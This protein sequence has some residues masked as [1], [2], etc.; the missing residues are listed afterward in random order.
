MADACL[1]VLRELAESEERYACDL[2][3]LELAVFA[4]FGHT[5]AI[6]AQVGAVI[7]AITRIRRAAHECARNI[8]AACNAV[9]VATS[10]GAALDV[11]LVNIGEMFNTMLQAC[12]QSYI[13][14]GENHALLGAYLEQH[15]KPVAA[16]S[17]RHAK[18]AVSSLSPSS[19]S[20]SLSSSPKTTPVV[21]PLQN[22]SRVG[23]QG[24]LH[25]DTLSIFAALHESD[26]IDCNTAR[27]RSTSYTHL[28]LVQRPAPAPAPAP[29]PDDADVSLSGVLS[30]AILAA[31][32]P[33]LFETFF[34]R[35]LL[36]V[37]FGSEGYVT[38]CVA[39]GRVRYLNRLINKRL[40]ARAKLDNAETLQMLLRK[41]RGCDA[42]TNEDVADEV[43]VRQTLAVADTADKWHVC[44]VFMTLSGTIYAFETADGRSA[45]PPLRATAK[46]GGHS[47]D[48]L[49]SP[50][51]NRGS[52]TPR[53][54]YAK[55]KEHKGAKLF[56][57]TVVDAQTQIVHDRGMASRNAA[58]PHLVQI[59]GISRVCAY[60]ADTRSAAVELLS[61]LRARG[62]PC[63][64]P[65]AAAAGSARRASV[66]AACSSAPSAG[67][68]PTGTA[69][70]LSPSAH[71]TIGS[72]RST[73]SS[74]SGVWADPV[75][76]PSPPPPDGETPPRGRLSPPFRLSLDVAAASTRG[77]CVADLGISPRGSVALERCAAG[78]V[79][80]PRS[81]DVAVPAMAHVLA[82]LVVDG[83]AER[84]AVLQDQLELLG[85]TTIGVASEAEALER[86]ARY[87]I[88]DERAISA[89]FIDVILAG[90]VVGARAALLVRRAVPDA[91]VVIT[92]DIVDFTDATVLAS[93]NTRYGI[94]AASS[95]LYLTTPATLSTLRD[96]CERAAGH[97]V[98]LFS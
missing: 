45:A 34:A 4:V 85:Y 82:V 28:P 87:G 72:A 59:V 79:H 67:S 24:M 13:V 51:R 5:T 3:R 47:L 54:S 88:G 38:T 66:D 42:D 56:Q 6:Y 37:P 74:D 19:S 52:E 17:P 93:F 23:A 78:A 81:G 83:D 2:E 21:P 27:R 16:Q 53:G 9:P 35:L 86:C 58:H 84:R 18:G 77:H 46:S 62:V 96:T 50:H 36:T 44:D 92:S 12:E 97:A 31:R 14:Y 15:W 1:P 39:L 41:V 26:G 40:V 61:F 94:D 71:T 89:A 11:L 30:L 48:S 65:P 60:A 10:D 95:I 75:P 80:H 70:S 68:T 32:R 22:V 90:G 91:A 69:R 25:K 43:A 73:S 20:S 33:C 8:M 98:C 76:P 64:G 63:F 7:A 49:L 55:N 57:R 29:R